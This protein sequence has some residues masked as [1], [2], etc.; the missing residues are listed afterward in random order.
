MGVKNETSL[1]RHVVIIPDGN[2]RWAKEHGKSTIDGHKAGVQIFE[3]ITMHAA[4]CGIEHLSAWGMSLDNFVKRSPQEVAGLL[5]I[6]YTEF[7]NLATSD[8]IH[9]RQVKI[10]VIGRWRKKFP[11][12][13]K[14]A[15]DEAIG[16]T[17]HYSRHFLNFFLA[18]GGTDEMLQAVKSMV[19]SGVKKV[20]PETLKEH[21]LTRDLPPVDL[22]IRT[23]GEPHNSDGFMMWDMADAQYYFTETCWPDFTTKDFDAALEDYAA[24]QRRFGK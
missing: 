1:P 10:N 6:F 8:K 17:E 7:K 23:G 19:K 24:R 22:L 3:D 9:D 4:D 2:R 18:Y 20:T 13:V 11:L 21:L 12:P 16:A 15:V 14:R 5:K